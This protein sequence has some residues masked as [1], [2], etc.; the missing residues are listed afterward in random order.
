MSNV[1]DI[2]QST[3]LLELT[4]PFDKR[5]VQLARRRQAKDWHPDLAPAGKQAAHERHLQ[6]INRAADQLEQLA[7]TLR[8]G[9]VSANAVKVSA[10]AA[11]KARAEEGQ[12]A[13][14]AEQ[15]RQESDKDRKVNDPFS[16]QVPDHSVVHRYARCLSYPEWGVGTVS[17]IY[18]TGGGDDIQQWARVSFQPGVRTV[19]ADSLQ[20]VD[21]SK[22]DPGADRVER[23]M[24]AARHALAEGAY[25]LAAQRLIYARD[26]D[27]QN[28][29]VLRLM[30]FAFWQDGEIE[31]AARAV[32]DWARVERERPAPQ[33]FAS[34]IYE[35]MRA[36]DLA[37]EA[38]ERAAELA[39]QDADAWERVGR[40]ALR[41][42]NPSRA[43]EVLELARE[44]A[45]T[46]EGLL[47][48][49]LA[50]QL[51]GD[52]GGELTACEQ[53]TVLEPDSAV[54]WSR[55]AHALARSDRLSDAV[56]AAERALMLEPGE[57][58]LTELLQQ[59]LD[60]QPRVL[61]AA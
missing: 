4:P 26:A 31:A 6:A 58:E 20:F 54:A 46:V 19:P 17:G 41:T 37:S 11:R 35:Q 5:D 28:P 39:P 34:R 29:A 13:W 33:R 21:F 14:E 42:G 40:L 47:D 25:G 3:L 61:P 15:R 22:P 45:P 48:L 9:R 23:F 36:F 12:R 7:E 55:L 51:V 43:V 27:P 60:R 50:N 38:A 44:L 32:R 2:E 16:S 59:L 30:T 18:F 57:K 52:L 1:L 53:A 49:A 56:A 24:T 10:A 8:G